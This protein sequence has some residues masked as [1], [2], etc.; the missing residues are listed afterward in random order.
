[1]IY[2]LI[3]AW[4]ITCMALR[5]KIETQDAVVPAGK[6]PVT[7]KIRVGVF[8]SRTVVTGWRD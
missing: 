1:M 5:P 6:T 7:E 8:T 3:A 2:L 4:F